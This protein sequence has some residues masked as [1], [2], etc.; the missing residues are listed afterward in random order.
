MANK[1]GLQ[2]LT[3]EQLLAASEK[4]EQALNKT[5]EIEIPR[6]GGTLLFKRPTD[7][8]M[9]SFINR[10][11]SA[12]SDELM[13]ITTD[14]MAKIIYACCE[15]LHDQELYEQLDVGDPVDVV[16]KIMD[17]GDI[18]TV[19]DKV[20]SMNSIYGNAAEEIKNA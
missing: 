6:L 20:C 12:D 16:H 3:L 11:N 1:E 2:R 5:E 17:S 13:E 19:G 10:V 14:E 4:R 15:Q 18:M 9:M 7:E 8:M